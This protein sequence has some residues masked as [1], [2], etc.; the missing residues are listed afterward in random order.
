MAAAT[1][2]FSP[3][4]RV[5]GAVLPEIADF[6]VQAPQLLQPP[7]HPVPGEVLVDEQRHHHAHAGVENA[8]EGVAD[9]GLRRGIEQQDAQH[10]AAGLDTAHPED[11]AQD[12]EQNR[13][14]EHQRHQQQR[15]APL[16][17]KNEVH[18]E[19]RHADHA[20]D[21]GA[22]QAVAAVELGVLHIGAQAEDGADAGKGGAAVKKEI[23]QGADGRRRGGLDGAHTHGGRTPVRLRGFHLLRGR[24]A[25]AGIGLH[26]CCLP[27]CIILRKASYKIIIA[28]SANLRM[29][30]L[31]KF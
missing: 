25:G 27:N 11:L 26:G 19:Q 7:L 31:L 29:P 4:F 3:S 1:R 10:H 23:D 14:D 13:A 18:A 6:A 16:R 22:E 9:V 30:S 24:R 28:R 8:V 17:V 12:D 5:A 2:L 21:D 20:A 15:P